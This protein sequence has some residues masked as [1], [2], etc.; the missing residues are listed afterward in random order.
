MAQPP[1]PTPGT[2]PPEIIA[3]LQQIAENLQSIR[4]NMQ[5]MQLIAADLLATV[6]EDITNPGAASAPET[7]REPYLNP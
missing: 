3:A 4:D 5:E 2:I 6:R 1:I 7:Q